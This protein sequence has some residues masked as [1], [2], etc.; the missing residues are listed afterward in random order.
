MATERFDK[1][2]KAKKEHILKSASRIFALYDY[3]SIN[4]SELADEAGI[5]RGS[6]YLYFK[7]K[8]DCFN[9][10]IE[11]H[12]DRIGKEFSKI[13]TQSET[14]TQ[15]IMATFEYIS[16]LS[17]FERELFNKI[18]HH[19]KISDN[20]IIYN[21]YKCSE[22]II[23]TKIRQIFEN[24]KIEITPNLEKEIPLISEIIYSFLLVTIIEF[25][26]NTTSTVEE[27]RGKLSIKLE[28]LLQMLS[29]LY[30]CKIV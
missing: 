22:N 15:V 20:D 24:G 25:N 7:D 26:A 10:V 8:D 13:I 17:K 30:Q 3:S 6:F 23:G 12:K 29:R 2:K 28:M 9:S 5:S 4:I 14:I 1:L 16:H 27:L 11:L 18:T 21:A 19:S